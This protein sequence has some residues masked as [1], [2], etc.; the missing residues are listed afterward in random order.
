MASFQGCKH[1][2]GPACTAGPFHQ[3]SPFDKAFCRA[4]PKRVFI[5]SSMIIALNEDNPE[6]ETFSIKRDEAVLLD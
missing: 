3:Y 5:A 2:N 4:I 6:R 1:L